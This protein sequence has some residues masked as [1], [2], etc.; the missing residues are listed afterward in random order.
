M[1]CLCKI[2]M[3]QFNQSSFNMSYT[4]QSKL[5]FIQ[6]LCIVQYDSSVSDWKLSGVWQKKL[7][8]KVCHIWLCTLKQIFFTYLKSIRLFLSFHFS[9]FGE[10]FK[11]SGSTPGSIITKKIL[12]EKVW[13]GK[14]WLLLRFDLF[15]VQT[16]FLHQIYLT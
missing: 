3:G 7:S 8:L 1:L 10:S 9:S 14:N 6:S 15:S 4:F 12:E 11:L 16:F 2:A 13:E 5:F